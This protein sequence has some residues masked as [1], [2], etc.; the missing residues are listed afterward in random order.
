MKKKEK[1]EKIMASFPSFRVN[2]PI[3]TENLNHTS[4]LLLEDTENGLKSKY[5]QKWS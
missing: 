4:D 3:T 2:S 5:K 1:K